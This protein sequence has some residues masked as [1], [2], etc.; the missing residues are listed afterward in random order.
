MNNNKKI[1]G[2]VFLIFL[3]VMGLINQLHILGDY[4]ELLAVGL[5]FLLMY[6]LRGAQKKYSNIGLLIPACVI[7]AAVPLDYIDKTK[8]V[9]VY[10][11][12][13][14]LA[15]LGTAFLLIYLIHTV[16][17]VDI[18]KGSKIWPIIVALILYVVS[19]ID[20][21]TEVVNS[22][23]GRLILNNFWPVILI[24]AGI[25]ILIRNFYRKNE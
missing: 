9:G 3:G 10:K 25:G 2:G 5:G 6:I 19:I 7:L 15:I 23:I 1:I 13:L 24:L 16:W 4:F 21:F 14:S 20:Y 17:V 11:D 12:P 18:K 8:M 22:E